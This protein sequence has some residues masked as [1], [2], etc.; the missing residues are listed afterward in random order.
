MSVVEFATDRH[1]IR[2]PMPA[3]TIWLSLKLKINCL[4]SVKKSAFLSQH[5]CG[6]WSCLS[7]ISKMRRN[8]NSA[9]CWTKISIS[10]VKNKTSLNPV[11]GMKIVISFPIFKNIC[12]FFFFFLCSVSVS[13]KAFCYSSWVL[14]FLMRNHSNESYWAVL[15]C[16][17]VYVL[18]KVSEPISA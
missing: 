6:L 12:S 16:F 3:F 5:E 17:A 2:Q 11:I 1:C 18:S 8:F 13:C 7:F 15:S 4:M 10:S 9:L 14:S